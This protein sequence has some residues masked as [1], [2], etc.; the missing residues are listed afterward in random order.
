LTAARSEKSSL[1]TSRDLSVAE[2]EQLYPTISMPVA[3]ALFD[4]GAPVISNGEE[5]GGDVN[6]ASVHADEGKEAPETDQKA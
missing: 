4:L 5:E 6:G 2:V 3:I 1:G